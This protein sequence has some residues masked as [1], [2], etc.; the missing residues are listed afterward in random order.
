MLTIY[1]A[2]A[3][4]GKT[5]N[6][7]YRYIRQ[8]LGRKSS[9]GQWRLAA[10]GQRRGRPHSHILAITFTNKAT[11]EMKH[12]IIR[13]LD[14]LASVPA[15]GERD[16]QFAAML[17]AD[18][19]CTRQELAA[20][21]AAALR[22]LL[23]DYSAFNVSTIDSFFQTVLRSFAREIDRQGDYRL[24]LDSDFAVTTAV[25]ML[26]DDV[27]FREKGV[28]ENV[29]RWL[30]DTA[31]RR[32]DQGQDF[33]PFNR[34]GA[35]FSDLTRYFNKT[36]N[37]TFTAHAGE[38]HDFLADEGALDRFC[39]AI[40]SN[41]EALARDVRDAAQLL[42]DTLAA[43][44]LSVEDLNASVAGLVGR[45]LAGTAFDDSVAKAVFEKESKRAKYLLALESRDESLFGRGG[46]FKAKVN[47]G[48]SAREALFRWFDTLRP[49]LVRTRVYT[50]VTK[51]ISTLKALTYIN[52]YINRF[53]Q[54]NNLILLEDTNSLLSSIISGA[55]APFIYERVGVELRHFLIDEFQ[56][57]SRLQWENL[58]PLVAN[59]MA[60]GD[61]S[62]IIGDVKQ[63]IYRWRGGDSSLLDRRVQQ[64]PALR[65]N[66][67]LGTTADRN[68]NWRS[69]HGMVR[70]NNTVFCRMAADAAVTGY[71][72][73]TQAVPENTGMLPTHINVRLL[74]SPDDETVRR[75]VAELTDGDPRLLEAC[76]D[77]G[78]FSRRRAAAVVCGCRIMR[79]HAA[80]YR[81][82]DIAVLCR[83]VAD[84]AMITGI[85]SEYFPEI[86]V[87]SGETL[88]LENAPAVKLIVSM[89]EII[90]CSYAGLLADTGTDSN[91]HTDVADLMMDRFEYY[92]AH[93]DTI[94]I[95]LDKALSGRADGR[96]DDP[97]AP[98]LI[99]DIA[100]LR[101]MAPANLL[102]TVEG[103]ISLKIPPAQRMAEL[104]YINAFLDA[105]CEFSDSHIPTV[106]AFLEYWA[107]VRHKL[108][109]AAPGGLDAVD[110]MT[111]H[112]AKGLEWPCVHIPVMDWELTARSSPAWFDLSVLDDIDAADRPP[113]L[114]MTPS[115]AFTQPGSPFRDAVAEQIRCDS[116]DN[117]NVA[118]VA[119]TR[120]VSEL[121]ITLTEA[122]TDGDGSLGDA[123]CRALR[124]HG[125]PPHAD[126]ANAA[127]YLDTAQYIDPGTG[128]FTIGEPTAP[129]QS[130]EKESGTK[131]KRR[132]VDPEPSAPDMP[133][134]NFGSTAARIARVDDLTADPSG[135]LDV[136][137][138]EPSPMQPLTDSDADTSARARGT[139]LHAVLA[140]MHTTD[141]LARAVD[142]VVYD[143]PDAPEGLADEYRSVLESAFEAAGD[144]A[145]AWFGPDTRRVLAEQ[146]VYDADR[147]DNWRPDRIVWT[148]DGHIDIIDYKFTSA[149]SPRHA[150][151]V[152]GYMNMLRSMGLDG[153]RG[154]V[155]YPDMR[156]IIPVDN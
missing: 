137:S 29:G 101:R 69:S 116:A 73:A 152:R 109:I 75:R 140:L 54:D 24:E 70:F 156:Q 92:L 17:T 63:S 87:M 33:N 108:S 13:E 138:G 52:D 56:D 135:G 10:P 28:A 96:A 139:G 97:E 78:T 14:A 76:M 128:D 72:G 77:G 141:D 21:A 117:L 26:F 130:A 55:D 20:A 151:Q 46:F 25:T 1:K 93:G 121:D 22:L 57:T 147:G 115:P 150:T 118:Y 37:E 16:S 110:I 31:L 84:G 102:S 60:S 125:L 105:V 114:Y 119:F 23:N 113:I 83:R 8:L 15:T 18:Y 89:L 68:T 155:W 74:N 132:L 143:M 126:G 62:L 134:F 41:I 7:A 149:P 2:S 106:H 99:S 100:R 35:V 34:N 6:L 103:I 112:K 51:S 38:L 45:S 88:M 42:C 4:S 71:E 11:A 111:V 120:A 136:E 64:D 36:F 107:T 82:K 122:V 9:G 48:D 80:G 49:A 61:D 40:D 43:E 58:Q 19:G 67:V 90:D 50:A 146:T 44:G 65:D 27:N 94:D 127:L 39:D 95:A 104:P 86:K 12:R 53:R 142:R 131:K 32:L 133:G 47:A 144:Y 123:L 154:F 91:T 79:Q 129:P 85:F 5:F 81:W 124:A 153:L 98:S 3:G 148:A 66:E 59:A 145:R 30:R